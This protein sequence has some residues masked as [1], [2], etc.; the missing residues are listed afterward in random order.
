MTRQDKVV[1]HLIHTGSCA[2]SPNNSLPGGAVTYGKAASISSGK[3]ASARSRSPLTENIAR[4]CAAP[5][6]RD[7]KVK[8]P[9]AGNP[10]HDDRLI[11]EIGAT[12]GGYR[13]RAYRQRQRSGVTRYAER[14][15]ACSG[16]LVTALFQG[17]SWHGCISG[18]M[19]VSARR[20]RVA[21]TWRLKRADRSPSAP[22]L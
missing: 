22:G 17:R 9:R 8:I 2:K 7:R 14:S 16:V 21:A 4:T 13:P 3:L 15:D 12:D 11:V 1:R 19:I 6:A 20:A 18:V 5:Q 10:T